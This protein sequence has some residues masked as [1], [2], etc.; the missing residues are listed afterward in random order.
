MK[1]K[2]AKITPRVARGNAGGRDASGS[3]YNRFT[4]RFIPS[5]MWTVLKLSRNPIR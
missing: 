2:D 1:S 4:T 5:R 3:R